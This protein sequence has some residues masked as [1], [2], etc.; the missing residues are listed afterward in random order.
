MSSG[1]CGVERVGSAPATLRSRR[2]FNQARTM[3][4]HRTPELIRVIARRAAADVAA[5]L[6]EVIFDHMCPTE[7]ASPVNRHHS[8]GEL[9][10]ESKAAGERSPQRLSAYESP[11]VNR[12][13]EARVD[14]KI[15]VVG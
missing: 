2:A 15:R 12:G 6:T 7:D 8:P 13:G 5:W 1:G 14:H 9:V 3:L 4:G 10:L 11:V